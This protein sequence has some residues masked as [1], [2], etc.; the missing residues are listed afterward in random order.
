MA[1][2]TYTEVSN[3]TGTSLSQ[4]VLEAIISQSDY[5]ID[6][7]LAESGVSGDSSNTLKSASL[8]LSIAGVL[9]REKMDGTSSSVVK[10]GE[11]SKEERDL[12]TMVKSLKEEAYRLVGA[13]IRSRATDYRNRVYKVN[14]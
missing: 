14:G 12:G 11:F 10:I 5:E 4:T 9:L 7:L 6:A 3:L 2:C 1:Y 8:K 13:Y